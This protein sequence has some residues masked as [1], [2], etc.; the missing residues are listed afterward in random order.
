[1]LISVVTEAYAGP[2]VLPN[3]KQTVFLCQRE[4]FNAL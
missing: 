4:Y 3:N 2:F 1:M